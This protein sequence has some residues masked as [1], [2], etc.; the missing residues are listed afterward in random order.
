VA[1]AGFLES[2]RLGIKPAGDQVIINSL[3]VVDAQVGV[4]TPNGIFWH[5]YNNDGYGETSCS[6]S[7]SGKISRLL[8]RQALQLVP[9]RLQLLRWPGHTPNSS[10]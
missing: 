6:L 1:D 2:I 8:G 4:T 5:R 9:V 7:R 10:G 3:Q